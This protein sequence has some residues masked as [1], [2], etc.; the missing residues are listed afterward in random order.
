MVKGELTTSCSILDRPNGVG[1]GSAQ[2]AD[3]I[4]GENSYKQGGVAFEQNAI[5]RGSHLGAQRGGFF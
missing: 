3:Q 1:M 2:T 4:G 5:D